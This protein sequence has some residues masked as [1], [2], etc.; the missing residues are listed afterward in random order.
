MTSSDWDILWSRFDRAL[1]WLIWGIAAIAFACLVR[2][3][4]MGAI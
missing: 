3:I 4:N 2:V 1:P